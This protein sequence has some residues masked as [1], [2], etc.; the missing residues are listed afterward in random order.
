MIL[1]LDYGVGNLRSVQ[2]AFEKAENDVRISS[3]FRLIAGADKVVLP[4]VGAFG[5]T[6]NIEKLGLR[7]P[8]LEWMRKGRP[9]LGICV[10]LQYLLT[11]GFEKGEH[12]GLGV[13]PGEVVRFKGPLKV[14]QIGW[15]QVRVLKADPL[16]R[17]IPDNTFF[18]FVH[19]YYAAP[20]D[21]GMVAGVTDYG[22]PY[23]SAVASG[24][25]FGVQFHPEKS[26]QAGLKLIHN[27]CRA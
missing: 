22:I 27:F 11:K 17:G 3:D 15:N 5:E 16:F 2:K 12:P 1:I 4:G 20:S 19:S 14:P 7:E 18:Y 6:R 26:Q 13:V 24:N 10:G 8:L 25:I 23:A 21:Q 9:F